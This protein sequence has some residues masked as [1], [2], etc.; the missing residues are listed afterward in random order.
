LGDRRGD[1]DL[2]RKA[3]FHFRKVIR[4]VAVD[5][6]QSLS[7]LLSGKLREILHAALKER[8]SAEFAAAE[9][10]REQYIAGLQEQLLRP[11]AQENL[12]DDLH[13]PRAAPVCASARSGL[14]FDKDYTLRLARAHG[15]GEDP[16]A[17]SMTTPLP[18]AALHGEA[19]A[20]QRE[21]LT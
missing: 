11:A 21:A 14:S 16:W 17:S 9:A 18:S 7:S 15:D 5:S 6:S 13:C 20:S 3:L 2:N 10:A 19:A 8:L 12:G 4:F 1:P